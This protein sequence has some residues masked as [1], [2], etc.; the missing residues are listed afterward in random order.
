MWWNGASSGACLRA[1]RGCCRQSRP[2]RGAAGCCRRFRQG[3]ARSVGGLQK[4]NTKNASK[5]DKEGVTQFKINRASCGAPM[6]SHS[7][8]KCSLSPRCRLRHVFPILAPLCDFHDVAIPSFI[9]V[10]SVFRNPQL[11]IAIPCLKWVNRATVLSPFKRKRKTSIAT[12]T[13]QHETTT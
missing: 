4:V 1:W 5:L 7:I 8:L 13:K 9:D 10:I 6:V 12:E 11:N 3:R 2:G